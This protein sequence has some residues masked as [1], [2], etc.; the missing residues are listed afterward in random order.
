MIFVVFIL[1]MVIMIAALD[2]EDVLKKL[3]SNYCGID[4]AF[5]ERWKLLFWDEDSDEEYTFRS[6]P[7]SEFIDQIESVLRTHSSLKDLDVRRVRASK[8]V[9]YRLMELLI[10]YTFDVKLD[11]DNT[12]LHDVYVQL[13]LEF[14]RSVSAFSRE[15]RIFVTL[16]K[17]GKHENLILPKFVVK[18]GRIIKMAFRKDMMDLETFR[19]TSHAIEENASLF[20]DI[21]WGMIVC[22]RDLHKQEYSHNKISLKS[23]AIEFPNQSQTQPRIKLMNLDEAFSSDVKITVDD[24]QLGID[25]EL[26]DPVDFLYYSPEKLEKKLHFGVYAD[27]WALGVAL[28]SLAIRDF[29]FTWKGLLS[30]EVQANIIKFP[31][32]LSAVQ[33]PPLNELLQKMMH[34][35]PESREALEDIENH[36]FL[37]IGWKSLSIIPTDG[38]SSNKPYSAIEIHGPAS[39]QRDIDGRRMIGAEYREIAEHE[40]RRFH[41]EY[42]QLLQEKLNV[43][44]FPIQSPVETR[45]ASQYNIESSKTGPGTIGLTHFASYRGD[46]TMFMLKTFRKDPLLLPLD[47]LFKMD[48][49]LQEGTIQDIFSGRIASPLVKEVQKEFLAKYDKLSLTLGEIYDSLRPVDGAEKEPF[50]HLLYE[51][52]RSHNDLRQMSVLDVFAGK[53][54]EMPI[55]TELSLHLQQKF[56]NIFGK[57][58]TEEYQEAIQNT[59]GDLED[60]IKELKVYLYLINN[61][62]EH[63]NLMS[64]DA[65]VKEFV[66]ASTVYTMIS[67]PKEGDDYDC[68]TT[69]HL[70]DPVDEFKQ[71]EVFKDVLLQM[72]SGVRALHDVRIAHRD[73]RPDNFVFQ[74]DE[75]SK[76]FIVKLFELGLAKFFDE[77]VT[78]IQGMWA[79]MCPEL[80]RGD[81]S[82]VDKE[83]AD[84][85]SLGVSFY[86]MATGLLPF[87]VAQLS[88]EQTKAFITNNPPDLE[89]VEHEPLLDLLQKM[90]DDEPSGR[91]SIKDLEKDDFFKQ[92]WKTLK[93][94]SDFPWPNKMILTQTKVYIVTDTSKEGRSPLQRPLMNIFAMVPDDSDDD[95]AKE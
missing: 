67:F 59:E 52:L 3:G 74:F 25:V 33:H 83:R 56:G 66:G 51:L 26:K 43:R 28:F 93:F 94:N 10:K 42:D 9:S 4:K 90:M 11:I 73:V 88:P 35:N 44:N 54:K 47:R 80:L 58:L 95:L 53:L 81:V 14:E 49:R 85:W 79:Y 89:D 5:M 86:V 1:F 64:V 68:Y 70:Q 92:G 87:A 46:G 75:K 48:R 72:L 34:M 24:P 21:I 50:V 31:P 7:E 12:T 45:F 27:I 16:V 38:S 32:D 6:H 78:H 20:Y 30:S 23:F 40:N 18:E 60:F 13:F 55:H 69:K 36:D 65:L 82:K 63:P 8:F 76:T 29:P 15:V 61:K 91:P 71:P 39:P 17:K 22:V 77:E 57:T 37:R 62:V 2:K 84:I 19:N 41:T